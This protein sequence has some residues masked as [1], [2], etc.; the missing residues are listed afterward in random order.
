MS[1]SMQRA[2]EHG[3]GTG[4]PTKAALYVVATP[5]GNLG[6]LTFRALEVLKKVEVIAA[7]DTRVTSK[8]LNHYAI[9]S[10]RLIALH[11]HNEQRTA[12]AIIEQLE[13]GRSVALVSDAGTPAIS[14]PGARLVAAV[15]EA[16]FSVVPIPGPNAAAAALSASGL[17]DAHFLF[18]GFLPAKTGERRKAI[19][20]LAA[21]PYTLVFYEAPHRALETVADLAA[22]LGPERG[23]VIAR[24]ITK[25]FETIHVCALGEAQTWLGAD[26]DRVK[27]EFVLIVQRAPE[28]GDTGLDHATQVLKILLEE[29]PVRQAAALA[30]RISGARKNELYALALELRRNTDDAP[31]ADRGS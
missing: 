20:A 18:Y 2:A 4:R 28:R 1:D 9:A 27:G 24:E 10:K 23:I 15:R 7:E 30:A 6:D 19:E 25:L 5:I 13:A 3:S 16:G 21:L 12:P 11:E 31:V 22:V 26:S 14:D 8:L 29:L 17:A